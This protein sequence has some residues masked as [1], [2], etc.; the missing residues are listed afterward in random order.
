[1]SAELD[2][3]IADVDGYSPTQAQAMLNALLPQMGND[4]SAKEA[5]LI[6]RLERRAAQGI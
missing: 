1:M 3:M 6:Q 2:K 5:L 4:Y